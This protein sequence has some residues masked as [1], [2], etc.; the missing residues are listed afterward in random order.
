[1]QS[2]QLLHVAMCA[3]IEERIEKGTV[4]V[5]HCSRGGRGEGRGG[6]SVGPKEKG[7]LYN[8]CD[9]FVKLL[10][11]RTNFS[12]MAKFISK[13]TQTQTDVDI[14]ICMC[15]DTGGVATRKLCSRLPTT[16]W[17]KVFSN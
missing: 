2:F 8:K 5:R 12:A 6:G 9:D 11:T 10:K 13:L 15:I 4:A 3:T 7:I 14:C 1:M 17:Q 16:A